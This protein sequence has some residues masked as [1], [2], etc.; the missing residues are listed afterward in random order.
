MFATLMATGDRST[1]SGRLTE[2]RMLIDGENACFDAEALASKIR[3]AIKNNAPGTI[4]KILRDQT[5]VQLTTASTNWLLTQSFNHAVLT[6]KST[7]QALWDEARW[8]LAVFPQKNTD[9]APCMWLDRSLRGLAETYLS[10]RFLQLFQNPKRALDL[11]LGASKRQEADMAIPQIVA[12]LKD[13]P[14]LTELDLSKLGRLGRCWGEAEMA[15]LFAAIPDE[16]KARFTAVN[17]VSVNIPSS[18]TLAA[19]TGLQKLVFV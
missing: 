9:Q 1:T 7:Q 16:I 15:A 5:G 10:P 3:A 6:Q 2:A 8:A 12:M 17:L 11:L 4:Q 14:A 13:S 19:F 18:F